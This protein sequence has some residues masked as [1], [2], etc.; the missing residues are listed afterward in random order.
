MGENL[1][2]LIRSRDGV[3]LACLLFGAAGLLLLI[4]CA[5]VT[6]LLLARGRHRV[7][8][9][10]VRYAGG[11]DRSRLIALLLCETLLVTFIAAVLAYIYIHY[12]F[13][14]MTAHAMA[15]YP[16]FLAAAVAARG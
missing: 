1:C 7:N 5:N 13:A 12:C 16:G 10:A 8:E 4:G 15:L 3:D 11:A 14:S 9:I 2:Y 6:I